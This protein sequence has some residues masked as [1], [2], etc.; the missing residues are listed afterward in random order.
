MFK[1][2]FL[3]FLLIHYFRKQCSMAFRVLVC[4][5]SSSVTR[6][7]QDHIIYDLMPYSSSYAVMFNEWYGIYVF[8]EC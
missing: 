1:Q 7:V 8:P 6:L 4:A 5:S 3:E 2:F